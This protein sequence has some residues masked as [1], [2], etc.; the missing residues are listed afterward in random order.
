LPLT[1]RDKPLPY[2]NTLLFK[3]SL[4][5]ENF[6]MATLEV[7]MPQDMINP[8]STCL[9][10]IDPRIRYGKLHF[11]FYSCSWDLW[12]GCPANLAGLP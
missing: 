9:R 10:L 2:N 5:G 6:T 1:A 4:K 8:K 7:G 12:S 3:A 11:I